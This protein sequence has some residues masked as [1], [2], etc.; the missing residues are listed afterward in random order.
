MKVWLKNPFEGEKNKKLYLSLYL[1]VI[2][3]LVR[4]VIMP[5]VEERKELEIRN[6]SL[7]KK[8]SKLSHIEH[9]L[10]KVRKENERIAATIERYKKLFFPSGTSDFLV[11]MTL[12]D[13]IFKAAV[14]SHLQ[15]KS[16]EVGQPAKKT[17][18]AV[19]PIEVKLKGNLI[20]LKNF[21]VSLGKEGKL[22]RVAQVRM[23]SNK[24]ILSITL[25][26]E[27]MRV[28]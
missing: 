27:G 24:D 17:G 25:V 2:V 12:I 13:A 28:E 14:K 6:K 22:I 9:S 3:A 11:S 19:F 21:L 10:N 18:I 7:D 8:L 16:C 26:C 4:L 23:Q 15:L 20:Q 5:L 1:L